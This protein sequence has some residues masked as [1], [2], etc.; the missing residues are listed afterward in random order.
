MKT[1]ILKFGLC[2]I[3]AGL[4]V[5]DANAQRTPRKRPTTP[6]TSNPNNQTD[7][8]TQQQQNNNNAQPSGYDP[9]AGIPI[10][11]DSTGASDTSIRKSLRNDNAFDKTS[12]TART[13]LQYEHLRWHQALYAEKDWRELDLREKM[14]QTFRY[15]A[16]D[17]NGSQMFIDMLLKADVSPSP[18]ELLADQAMIGL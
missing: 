1:S 11:K 7:P 2:V 9:Y 5:N 14:N 10:I 13:P 16:K 12:L 3:V 6:T 8:T 18:C 15:E 17:D 4:L